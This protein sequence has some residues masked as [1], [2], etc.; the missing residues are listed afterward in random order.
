MSVSRCNVSPQWWHPVIGKQCF[1]TLQY[2][3]SRLN[4]EAEIDPNH[5]WNHFNQ[6][7]V[8]HICFMTLNF[9]SLN[10]CSHIVGLCR[11]T[12]DMEVSLLLSLRNFFSLSVLRVCLCGDVSV[13]FCGV[14]C[15]YVCLCVA[16]GCWFV[17]DRDLTDGLCGEVFPA[18]R[19]LLPSL[20]PLSPS[21]VLIPSPSVP[22]SA[23]VQHSETFS[24][25][26]CSCCTRTHSHAD[27]KRILH[28]FIS[29]GTSVCDL[30]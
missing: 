23:C 9:W 13:W 20:P 21:F 10:T 17:L 19:S 24:L 27:K 30:V 5:V 6:F 25:F 14:L 1:T 16:L 22:L 7:R 29:K 4:S 26:V 28:K 18:A 12:T 11:T 3:S 2:K 15:V 8:F